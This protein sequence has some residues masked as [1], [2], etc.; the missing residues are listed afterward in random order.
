M[1]TLSEDDLL[2]HLAKDSR[3]RWELSQSL[4]GSGTR[5]QL[6]FLATQVGGDRRS[7]ALLHWM[8]EAGA[9]ALASRLGEGCDGLTQRMAAVTL[10]GSGENGLAALDAVLAGPD[11]LA[12]RNA[13]EALAF[14]GGCERMVA[15]L[16]HPEADVRLC[17]VYGLSRAPQLPLSAAR[18]LG[19]RLKDAEPAV[20]QLAAEALEARERLG[21]TALAEQL[22][23]ADAWQ[24]AAQSLRRLG[25]CGAKGACEALGLAV[26]PARRRAADLLVEMGEAG[27]QAALSCLGDQRPDVR[28]RAA[29]AGSFTA[30]RHFTSGLGGE[31]QNAVFIARC[32]VIG[33]C[34]SCL[35]RLSG[36][37]LV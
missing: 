3:H 10:Q 35:A 11:R 30:C 9:T 37:V 25:A 32:F 5:Q 16:E 6:E 33:W 36:D 19:A 24:L 23:E 4:A 27:A 28:R 1:E 17:A 22:G 7:A 34:L 12:R 2:A 14:C 29:E 26:P 18:S 13:A 15:R 8:G 20:R 21:A 31:G